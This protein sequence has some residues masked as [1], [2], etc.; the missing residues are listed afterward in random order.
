MLGSLKA[1]D[2]SAEGRLAEIRGHF[3]I[4]ADSANYDVVE[5]M[6]NGVL[7]IF[8]GYSS[9]MIEGDQQ[10]LQQMQEV[11]QTWEANWD[12]LP[13]KE[14]IDFVKNDDNMIPNGKMML[15]VFPCTGF[16]LPVNADNA[17][18]S[19][20]I[21]SN[22]K[23]SCEKEIR[24]SMGESRGLTKEQV[25]ILDV[26]AN[27]DWKRAIYF[28][29]PAGSEIAMSILKTGHLRQNG[30]AWE[31]SPI[32]SRD[33]LN[34]ERMYHN[35]MVT[36]SYGKMFD[37][38]VLTDY[39]ARRQTSQFR[40]QFAQLADYYVNKAQEEQQNQSQYTM[41]A[42]NMRA[43]G[44]SQRADSLMKTLNGAEGRIKEYNKRAIALVNKC[45]QVMPLKTV[46]DYGEPQPTK[47][48]LTAPDGLK[49]TA[50]QDG[51]VHDLVTILYRAGD[52][53]RG[54]QLGMEVADQLESIINFFLKS[55]PEL[56]GKNINDLSSAVSNYLVVY[57]IA[58]DPQFGGNSKL[59]SRTEKMVTSL[60]QRDFPTLYKA[61][62]AKARENM[63]IVR[64]GT[65]GG[66]AALYFRVQGTLDA[67]GIEQGILQAPAPT[68]PP[69]G[70]PPVNVPQMPN[71]AIVPESQGSPVMMN[72]NGPQ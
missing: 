58:N 72:P 8:N 14:A 49:Y 13:V 60:Y 12:Y 35:L 41:I 32:R 20:M 29:S 70:Q 23:A 37:P 5:A 61:L 44:Q 31:V 40:S 50:Y 45:M 33:G 30:M 67:L 27:N 55:E 57:R 64:P 2:P 1:K 69:A 10:S 21:A 24:F 47:R 52:K 68:A 38:N 7:E 59:A 26:L 53:K 15:R 3:A 9:G 66:Y 46:I 39:Y 65:E 17:V 51:T 62:E 28:S 48:Q 71:D 36:Y 25:M 43:G 34:A 11:L 6:T 56:A 4:P 22:E 18:K 19:E 63:E 54:E 16:I 42:K